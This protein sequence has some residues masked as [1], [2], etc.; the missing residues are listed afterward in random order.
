MADSPSDSNSNTPSLTTANELKAE[1]N[2]HFRQSRWTEALASYRTALSHL[3][4]QQREPTP[5][6][7]PRD[8]PAEELDKDKNDSVP[9]PTTDDHPPVEEPAPNLIVDV[10]EHA[11]ARAIL[12]ANIGACHTK[13]GDHK[14]AVEA[15]TQALLDDPSYVKARQ[16]RATSN[17]QIGSWSSLSSAQEDFTK[18]LGLLPSPSPQRTEAERTLASLKPRVEAAQKQETAEMVDKLKGLGNSIL[19]RFGLSTDNFKFDP[20]GQGGYSV[21][22][23]PSK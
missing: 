2:D 3:P 17:M 9:E 13:M 4:P 10:D 11:K 5:S 18:L 12:N 14:L 22:F 20:N 23:Q 7:I 19:G 16:R 21:N 6:T 1:G 8:V 15:C